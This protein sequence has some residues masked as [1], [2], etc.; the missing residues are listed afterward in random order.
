MNFLD[1][2]FELFSLSGFIGNGEENKVDIDPIN[3]KMILFSILLLIASGLILYFF[4]SDF[5]ELKKLFISFLISFGGSLLFSFG[6]ILIL[7][8][9]K[10]IH[11]LTVSSFVISLISSSIFLSL[12]I[13]LLKI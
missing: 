6:L 10:I 1:F 7:N 9:Y 8:K 5:F 4:K 13:L 3:R 12:I 11:S 2:I